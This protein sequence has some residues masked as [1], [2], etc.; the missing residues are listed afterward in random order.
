M[1]LSSLTA[2][3]S[4]VHPF[5]NKEQVSLVI[6]PFSSEYITNHSANIYLAFSVSLLSGPS[7]G[8]LAIS[9]SI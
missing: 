6:A 8:A 3:Y 1:I 4:L 7:K 2:G 5:I 9:S